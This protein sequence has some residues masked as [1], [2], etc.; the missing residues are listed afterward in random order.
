QIRAAQI[1]QRQLHLPH[2]ELTALQ[3]EW[4]RDRLSG[5]YRAR[6]RDRV[7][8]N[9]REMP[10][11]IERRRELIVRA[12]STAAR[13]QPEAATE[14]QDDSPS[15]T[16]PRRQRRAVSCH[17]GCHDE[18]KAST[19]KQALSAPTMQPGLP[20]RSGSL[21][22][23]ARMEPRANGGS[24]RQ[25]V[26][27]RRSACTVYAP[28]P[29]TCTKRSSSAIQAVSWPPYTQP[30]SRPRTRVPTTSPRRAQWPKTTMR[31]P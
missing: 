26:R 27:Q 2:D 10:E 30:V 18:S 22:A 19:P 25:P 29:G 17:R 15:S 12:S 3:L 7:E 20:F 16:S 4:Q 31:A 21:I 28:S 1:A 5:L 9:R 11:V 8:V 6:E 24:E 23:R 13:D 14:E